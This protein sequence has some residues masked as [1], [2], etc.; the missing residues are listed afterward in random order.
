MELLIIIIFLFIVTR[1]I[2]KKRA[3][4][5][6]RIA[7]D[8]SIAGRQSKKAIRNFRK[9]IDDFEREQKEDTF[10]QLKQ[11]KLDNQALRQE[12]NSTKS[13]NQ[14]M[15][16][17]LQYEQKV[18]SASQRMQFYKRQSTK[19]IDTENRELEKMKL[20]R[21]QEEVRRLKLEQQKMD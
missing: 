7:Y 20:A 10:A 19:L 12:L 17:K 1:V 16:E 13:A 5:D 11:L 8:K 6:N 4:V 15:S 21:L 14:R 18:N 3:P 2:K 9:F